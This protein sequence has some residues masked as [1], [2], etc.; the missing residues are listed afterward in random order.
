VGQRLEFLC[1]WIFV[2]F[3]AFPAFRKKAQKKRKVW[4]QCCSLILSANCHLVFCMV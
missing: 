1:P 3:R 2:A 4:Q